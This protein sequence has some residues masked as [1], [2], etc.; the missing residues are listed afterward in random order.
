MVMIAPSILSADFTRLGEEIRQAEEAGADM[1]HIDVMDGHFVPNIS[2]GQ[3]VV[4]GIRKATG[5]PFDVHLM[6]EDPDRYLSDFVNAGADIITVHLEATSHL[7]RTVQWIKE[8]GKKAGVSINPATPV[9]SLES[10]LSE[11]DLVLVMSVNPGFGGQSFI[12]QSLDKIRMLKRIVRERGLDILVEVDGGVKID[13]AREI[14]DAG[15][16]IMVMGSAF[17]NSEDYSEVVR[18]FRVENGA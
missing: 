9:W 10:I 5:L 1:I 18:R 14:A 11:V 8:S 15:A 13:N 16:D 2:I 3:E 7:H 17:F 6:I 12:P 4:R